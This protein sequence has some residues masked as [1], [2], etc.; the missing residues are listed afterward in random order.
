MIGMG[1]IWEFLGIRLGTFITS[2]SCITTFMANFYSSQKH[3]NLVKS[4][5][6][7][8]IVFT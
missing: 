5:S 8:A 1:G 2:K 7:S 6:V 4:V 3:I